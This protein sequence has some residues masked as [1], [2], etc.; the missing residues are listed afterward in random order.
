MGDYIHGVK[1]HEV[2][3]TVVTKYNVR[4]VTQCTR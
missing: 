4:G 1:Y 3:N 2:K